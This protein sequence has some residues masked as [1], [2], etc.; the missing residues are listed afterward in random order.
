MDPHQTFLDMFQAM[1]DEDHA[2]AQE[3][4]YA[5]QRWFANGGFY[6]HEYSPDAIHCYVASVLRR[7]SG[8]AKPEP[9]FSVVCCYCDAGQGIPTEEMAMDEGWTEIE[10]DPDL[11]QANFL[12]ICPDCRQ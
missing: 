3:L 1:K 10:P 9:V 12:G 11:L 6:P 2:T 5:L 8:H 4:A 7:T